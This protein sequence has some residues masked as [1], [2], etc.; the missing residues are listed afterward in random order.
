[1]D[2]EYTALDLGHTAVFHTLQTDGSAAD[3]LAMVVHRRKHTV[4]E[5]VAFDS[6][7][8]PDNHLG[9]AQKVPGTGCSSHQPDLVAPLQMNKVYG[10]SGML[11]TRKYVK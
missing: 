1:M 10:E 3:L 11:C 2:F 5:E 6:H 9:E 8:C 4:V 7:Y